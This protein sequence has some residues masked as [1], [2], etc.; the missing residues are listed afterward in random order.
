MAPTK[1]LIKCKENSIL[2][3]ISQKSWPGMHAGSDADRE[4]GIGIEPGIGA[5]AGLLSL[6]AIFSSVCQTCKIEN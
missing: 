1:L 2:I 3:K 5:G 4:I 6:C